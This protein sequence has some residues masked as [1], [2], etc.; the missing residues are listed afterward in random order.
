MK[1][2]LFCI[3]LIIT[4]ISLGACSN[5]DNP[6]NG[7][8]DLGKRG[9]CTTCYDN[10]IGLGEEINYRLDSWWTDDELS[11][12]IKD[13]K[14]IQKDPVQYVNADIETKFL[15]IQFE[16]IDSFTIKC[17][18]VFSQSIHIQEL[19]LKTDKYLVTLPIDLTLT[20]N[21]D[22]REYA[23]FPDSVTYTDSLE[24]EVR[25]ALV[26]HPSFLKYDSKVDTIVINSIE[27]KSNWILI[28]M[29]SFLVDEDFL[30]HFPF[31][32]EC[33]FP[34]NISEFKM[35]NVFLIKCA[36]TSPNT[37]GITRSYDIFVNYMVNGDTFTKPIHA[38]S[39]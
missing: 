28:E 16:R 5:N 25:Y 19:T 17:Q 26:L 32:E 7:L 35:D 23:P 21:K 34:V 4:G 8:V 9:D 39:C 14:I 36:C 33:V 24:N 13:G 18:D 15:D 1:K 38:L 3:W 27:I 10:F 37:D 31:N 22:Y 20:Y 6:N 2:I 29:I 12:L 30:C 11:Q